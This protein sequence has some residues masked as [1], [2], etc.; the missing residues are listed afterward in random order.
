MTEVQIFDDVTGEQP[1][2]PTLQSKG[3]SGYKRLKV[4]HRTL[5]EEHER[6]KADHQE[7]LAERESLQT[8]IDKLLQQHNRLMQNVRTPQPQLSWFEGA[9]LVISQLAANPEP[10]ACKLMEATLV[11]LLQRAI[12]LGRMP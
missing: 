8:D 4:R 11:G 5:I 2:Q 9:S 1:S 7:L 6:L 3:S 12:G 10:Q